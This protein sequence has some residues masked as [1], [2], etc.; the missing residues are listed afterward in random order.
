M[1][2]ENRV[3]LKSNFINAEDS[4]GFL[5]W[6]ASNLLQ[7]SHSSALKEIKLTPAQFSFMTCLVY[8]SQFDKATSALISKHSGMDKMM[9][10]DLV[11][12]LLRKKM[13]EVEPNSMDR[14]S[15]FLR[16]SKNGVRLTNLAIHKI[17]KIDLIFFSE[18]GKKNLE[19]HLKKL[20]NSNSIL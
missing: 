7:K 13:I 8:L 12:T 9:I 18:S 14:R 2:K 3:K 6:K 19:M 11:K 15:F 20:I 10:S 16:P 4:L 5:L 1:P 17:E